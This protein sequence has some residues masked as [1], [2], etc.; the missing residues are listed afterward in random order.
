MHRSK[1][2]VTVLTED[3]RAEASDNQNYVNGGWFEQKRFEEQVDKEEI[4]SPESWE[5]DRKLHEGF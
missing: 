5:T 1:K 3:V 2:K 4:R